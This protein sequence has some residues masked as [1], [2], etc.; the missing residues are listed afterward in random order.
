MSVFLSSVHKILAQSKSRKADA[1]TFILRKNLRFQ[2][3]LKKKTTQ[4]LPTIMKNNLAELGAKM[5]FFRKESSDRFFPNLILNVLEHL[6]LYKELFS[7][8]A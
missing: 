1:I 4:I 3:N 6:S 5:P 7:S 2:P 8:I